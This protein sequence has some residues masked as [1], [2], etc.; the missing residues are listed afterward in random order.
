MELGDILPTENKYPDN[1]IDRS[2]ENNFGNNLPFPPENDNH[3]PS[4]PPSEP[5]VSVVPDHDTEHSS[6][7]QRNPP[8][9]L[10]Q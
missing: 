10:P 4:S 2:N 6:H 8:V 7:T 3:P 9:L 1:P 5:E